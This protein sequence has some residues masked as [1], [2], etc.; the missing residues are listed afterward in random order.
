MQRL[1]QLSFARLQLQVLELHG[2]AHVPRDL[3]LALE[4][5]L[6]IGWGEGGGDG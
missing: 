5:C 6:G 1:L 3:Q 2:Q 4:K